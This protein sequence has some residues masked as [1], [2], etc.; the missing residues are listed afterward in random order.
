MAS[1]HLRQ[2]R[3]LPAPGWGRVVLAVLAAVAVAPSAATASRVEV[4]HGRLVYSAAPGEVNDV[5][6]TGGV[7][8]FVVRDPGATMRA[9]ARC[10]LKTPNQAECRV[11]GI[12]RIDVLTSD[13][14][15]KVSLAAT[16]IPS[17]IFGGDGADSLAGGGGPDKIYGSTGDDV[18]LGRGGDDVMRGGKDGDRVD[19]GDGSDLVFGQTGDDV[20][21][22]GAGSDQLDGGPGYDTARYT[23]RVAPLNVTVDGMANDGELGEGDNVMLTMERVDGGAGADVLAANHPLLG[24]PR[25]TAL[26]GNRGDDRLLGGAGD[27]ELRGGPG[28]DTLEGG[29]GVDLLDGGGDPD[30]LRAGAGDDQVGA[31]DGSPDLVDCGPGADAAA[32]DRS[33]R[34][35]K[36]CEEHLA[37]GVA[38]SSSQI[39]GVLTGPPKGRFKRLHG[40]RRVQVFLPSRSRRRVSLDVV[41]TTQ[42]GHRLRQVHVRVRTNRWVTLRGLRVPRRARV[43]KL[44]V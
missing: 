37:G 5:L 17:L 28:L 35:A 20:L 15:D 43:I 34:S 41:L 2:A 40:H 44:V 24:H 26:R 9:G 27:D 31:S 32:L 30:V 38:P 36:E 22:G 33:D 4:Y 42:D 7:R 25:G 12:V 3:C 21:D 13:L 10:V 11:D 23:F 1:L 16:P 8:A 18:V 19:G 29:P 39:G 6:V 14:D